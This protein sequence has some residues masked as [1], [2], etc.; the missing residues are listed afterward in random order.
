MFRPPDMSWSGMTHADRS[1]ARSLR[2]M[3]A[4]RDPSGLRDPSRRGFCGMRHA[5]L[6]VAIVPLAGGS[7]ASAG[8]PPPPKQAPSAPAPAAPTPAPAAPTPAPAAPAPTPAPAAAA[9][10]KPSGVVLFEIA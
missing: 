6:L 3:L 4:R 8:P 9:A 7:N 5:L 10:C 1:M 2:A